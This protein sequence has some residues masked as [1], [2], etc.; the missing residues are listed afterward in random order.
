MVFKRR[1]SSLLQANDHYFVAV[2]SQ[3]AVTSELEAI[4]LPSMKSF[5]F[6]I[7]IHET[8]S[9]EAEHFHILISLIPLM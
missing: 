9:F 7:L 8:S 4:L 6:Q 3:K 5:D 1:Q 2:F